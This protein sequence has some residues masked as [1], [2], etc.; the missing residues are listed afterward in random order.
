MLGE[1]EHFQKCFVTTFIYS[2]KVKKG[3][4]VMTSI[5]NMKV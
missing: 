3:A 1:K 2:F 4:A 5:G